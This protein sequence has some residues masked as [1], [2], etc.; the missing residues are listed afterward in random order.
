MP[1]D[2]AAEIASILEDLIGAI[3]ANL[4][5]NRAAGREAADDLA[6]LAVRA[7]TIQ[8]TIGFRSD[9]QKTP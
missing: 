1:D 6:R 4:D 9:E 8:T 5:L 2:D 7:H 3:S